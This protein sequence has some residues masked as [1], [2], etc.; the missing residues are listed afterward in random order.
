MKVSKEYTLDNEGAFGVVKIQVID[1]IETFGDDKVVIL[2]STESESF[3]FALKHN[4]WESLV[5][6]L[7]KDLIN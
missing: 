1:S 4:E 6:Q 2:I 7:N 3:S 5:R